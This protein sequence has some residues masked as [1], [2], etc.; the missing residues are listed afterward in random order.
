MSASSSKA[1]VTG[2]AG[3]LG[4]H[5]CEALLARGDTVI[6]LDSFSDYY[7][8]S[9]K[10]LN[11]AGV[12]DQPRF[13]LLETDLA[14]DPLGPALD[15]VDTVFHLAAQPGVRLSFGHGFGAYLRDNVQA[16]Q[17]L[18]E[19]VAGRELSAFVY[20]SSSS[21]YGDQD[22]Y[23]VTEDAPLRPVSP[24][25]ATKVITEQLAGGFWRSAGIPVVGLRYFTVYGPRQRPDMAFTR[26]LSSALADR[27]LPVLGDGRQVREFTYV[28]DVISATIAAAERGTPGAVYNVGG[29]VPVSLLEVIDLLG[30]LLGR[31]PA[32]EHREVAIGDPRRTDADITR[33]AR[34]LGYRPATSLAQGLTAQFEAARAWPA[35][36]APLTARR[37]AG[38]DR[39][40]RRRPT[41][42][43]S[44]ATGA[45]A[46]AGPRVL[47][48]S[49]DGYGL[50]H[51]RRNLRIVSGLRRQRPDLEALLVTGAKSAERLTAPFALDCVQLAPV[52]KV[53][54]GRYVSAD[55]GGS[56][57]DVLRARSAAILDVVR[58]FVPDLILVDRY[59][60]G[61]HDELAPALRQ[62][63][64]QRPGAPAVLGL[65]DI[66]D[67]PET[68]RAEW[69]TNG[70]S[71]AIRETYAMVLCY[72]DPTVYD[73][74]SEY[75]LP[76]DIAARI[77][78]TG[79]LAD[80][81]LAADSVEV[82]RRHRKAQ[83]RLAVCTLGGGRDASPI[84]ESFL[85]AMA[86]LEGRGW[87]GVLITGPYMA[88]EDVERLQRHEATRSVS[89]LRMVDDV[90]S[91]LAAA[92]A[93][94]SMG[95]YNT[96]C[97]LLALAVPAV[98]VPRV[99]PREEQRM[100]AERLGA[101]G[102]VQ[103]IEPTALSPGVLAA[104]IERVTAI[105][106][107][108]LAGRIGRIDHRGIQAA[109]HH[110]AALLPAAEVAETS[111]TQT[112]TG[113]ATAWGHGSR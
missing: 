73:P 97:E 96:V 15:G 105:P 69:R 25:G 10:E 80:D 29:G 20:A 45:R 36:V 53:A 112:M 17:R 31:A 18:L 108:E 51:L 50:G 49:H 94:V 19:A 21:V 82:R 3:F 104:G 91:Y 28:Q 65:R 7:A 61:M 22:V 101:C 32:V 84:A 110:L 106:R 56:V 92:D 72:G 54:N 55:D 99:H 109:A 93:V 81:L 67:R 14:R 23:P 34:E 98:I 78:F 12:R 95:G 89:V 9:V 90:P 111:A 102:L 48:Y 76:D 113:S 107:A 41:S 68:I 8:R 1:L 86:E 4:S 71:A 63:A 64:A 58:R 100:R 44:R 37:H 70:Y 103:W 24:Y 16:T 59:P 47:A 66:L 35:A 74:V 33:A 27:P 13:T 75:G 77:R 46:G 88:P 87:S 79:Y 11:L 2:C 38:I 43:S 40:R 42:A 6:G 30:E 85:S 5:L 83:R 57:D 52:A 39:N 26:F 62:H 60:R